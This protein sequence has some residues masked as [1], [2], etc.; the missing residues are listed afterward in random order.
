MHVHSAAKIS[1]LIRHCASRW[2]DVTTNDGPGI[3]FDIFFFRVKMLANG[4]FVSQKKSSRI[5]RI[6]CGFF[7][8]FL[9]E[10]S[11]LTYSN[12]WRM[13]PFLFF[14]YSHT[15][16]P[17]LASFQT[18]AAADA[19]IYDDQGRV[20]QSLLVGGLVNNHREPCH[21]ERSTSRADDDDIVFG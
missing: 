12:S 20:S 4:R 14:I 7:F 16:Y 17:T 8:F 5:R 13:Q 19:T 6:W 3:S 18:A 15:K 11:V 1:P 10:G 9:P 2:S 21:E